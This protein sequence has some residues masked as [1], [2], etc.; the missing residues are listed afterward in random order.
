MINIFSCWFNG[1]GVQ[2]DLV[3]VWKQCFVFWVIYTF[4]PEEHKLLEMENKNLLVEYQEKPLTNLENQNRILRP[5]Q[6]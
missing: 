6:K 1:I 4:K 5:W 2:N 3:T